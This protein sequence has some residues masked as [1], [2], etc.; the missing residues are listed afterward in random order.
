MV[1]KHVTFYSN[2][3]NGLIKKSRSRRLLLHDY[4]FFKLK[5]LGDKLWLCPFLLIFQRRKFFLNMR[6]WTFILENHRCRV[7]IWLVRWI[8]N[9]YTALLQFPLLRYRNLQFFTAHYRLFLFL[10]S[11]IIRYY[12]L[13]S[14]LLF[15][16]LPLQKEL[17]WFCMKFLFHPLQFLLRVQGSLEQQEFFSPVWWPLLWRGLQLKRFYRNLD[18]FSWRLFWAHQLWRL[19]VNTSFYFPQRCLVSYF[20][21]VYFVHCWLY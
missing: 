10:S 13:Y 9:L 19:L 12:L 4:T 21:R 1:L 5:T 17:H 18:R 11:L 8:N 15:L 16:P 14:N 7:C 3:W 6:N 20:C 2:T